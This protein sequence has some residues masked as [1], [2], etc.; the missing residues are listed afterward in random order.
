M[1]IF[2]SYYFKC[3]FLLLKP[4]FFILPFK[5]VIPKVET[6]AI[7]MIIINFI[8]ATKT[9]R[10]ITITVTLKLKFP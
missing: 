4:V 3:Y 10:E 2:S 6:M 1:L 5:L 7:R 8:I 9:I